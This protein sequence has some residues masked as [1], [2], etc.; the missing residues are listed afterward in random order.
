[1]I[2]GIWFLVS[3]IFSKGI[4]WEIIVPNQARI[5]WISSFNDV[6]KKGFSLMNSRKSRSY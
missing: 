4:I 5:E 3:F 6:G 2:E 1:M